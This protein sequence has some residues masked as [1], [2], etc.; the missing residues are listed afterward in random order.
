MNHLACL[1]LLS[2]CLALAQDT[3]KPIV[4]PKVVFEEQNN[5][6]FLE[7]EYFY[8]QTHTPKRQWHIRGREAVHH[9]DAGAGAYIEVFPDTRRTHDD[10]LIPGENF[11]NQAGELAVIYYKVY[12]HHPGR[13]YLWVRAFSTGTEDNG[14]HAGLD[15]QWPASGQRLQWCEGK[16]QWTWASKQR[17]QANHC[18]EPFKIFLDIDRPGLHELQF[19]MREDGFRM[20]QMLLSTDPHFDPKNAPARP[21]VRKG[22]LP[23]LH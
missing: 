12:F 11:S 3:W 8:R 20:D 14:V 13:Y 22:K 2:P 18:G 6:V 19:S 5:L 1:L 17:T 23:R 9:N 4:K 16:N 7:A 10:P 21:Y 15:G